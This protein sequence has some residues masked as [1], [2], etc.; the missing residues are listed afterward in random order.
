MDFAEIANINVE[1][2]P[3]VKLMPRGTYVWAVDRVPENK[4]SKKGFGTTISVRLKCLHAIDEFEDP[5]ALKDF[6]SPAGTVR[7]LYFYVP[8]KPNDEQDEGQ[9]QQ[10]QAKA[11]KRLMDF[12]SNDLQVKGT[13]LG[14]RL[15]LCVHHQCLGTITHKPDDRN[16]QE[17]VDDLSG[18][19]PLPE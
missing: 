17:M 12:L 14:E 15:S 3:E 13:T 6:G 2:L 9:F 11:I 16:P 19:A 8:T 5:D 4:P 1:D 18:T 10:A 7:T